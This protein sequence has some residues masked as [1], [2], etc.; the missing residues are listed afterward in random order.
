MLF[1]SKLLIG[2][3]PSSLKN[4]FQ[5][6][7]DAFHVAVNTFEDLSLDAQDGILVEELLITGRKLETSFNSLLDNEDSINTLTENLKKNQ[8]V[9]Y[10]NLAQ[11]NKD[12][13]VRNEKLQYQLKIV[14]YISFGFFL[15]LLGFLVESSRKLI[16]AF[17]Q[18]VIDT[19]K[20]QKDLSYRI[21]TA[22]GDYQEFLIVSNALNAMARNH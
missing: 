9:L 20:I 6:K 16:L 12:I 18:I 15:L 3:P 2:E 22:K 4:E 11:K 13:S 19:K 17:Q 7:I 8:N 14:Q 1:S 10:G 5:Q 21:N